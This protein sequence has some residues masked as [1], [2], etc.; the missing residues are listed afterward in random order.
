MN[1]TQLARALGFAVV[2]LFLTE[3]FAVAQGQ[4]W[5]KRLADAATLRWLQGKV[6][7]GNEKLNHWAYDKSVLCSGLIDVSRL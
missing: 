6:A 1:W 3:D 4:I 5:A 2:F 7:R